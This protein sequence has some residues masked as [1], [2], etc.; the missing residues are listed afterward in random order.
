[1]VTS[2]INQIPTWIWFAAITLNLAMMIFNK[3]NGSIGYALLNLASGL[4]CCMG[5]QVSK[6]FKGEDK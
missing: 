3:L 1:M 2:F 4:L 6:Y 5:L